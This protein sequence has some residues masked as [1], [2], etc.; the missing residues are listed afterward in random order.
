[1]PEFAYIARDPSGSRTT[2]VVSASSEREAI[3]AI[4]SRS[5]F[6]VEV[7]MDEPHT[8][9]VRRRRISGQ[10]MVNTYGQLSALL[11][12][13]VS[14]LRSLDVIRGQISHP[15]LSAVL[16]DIRDR[17]EDGASLAEAMGRHP[18]VFSEIAVS[19]V[20]AGGEG[21]FLEEALDR[22]AAFAEQQD[23]L[24]SRVIGA[25]A[26]PVFLLVLCT[27]VVTGLMIFFVPS[28]EEIFARLRERGELPLPTE[29]LL[30]TSS[31][32]KNWGWAAVLAVIAIGVL[33]YR[34]LQTVNGR[35][36]LDAAKLR[37]PMA[38]TIFQSLAVSRFCRVLGTLL[39]NGVPILRSL[40]ISRDAASNRVLSSAIA[41]ASE[42]I[43]AGQALA[44]PLGRCD[45]F[46][47]DVVE[48]IAVAE[49]SNTLDK[50]LVNIADRLD[51]NTTRRLELLVRLI[52]PLMLLGLAGLV[53]MIVIALLIPV[54]RM[55]SSI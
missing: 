34:W 31:T 53:L 40:E 17:V 20:R 13:G 28:F 1:M 7:K 23:D 44:E 14:L 22:V 48:I 52:E 27:I 43:S 51:R 39:R 47:R 4:S 38:G 6:P 35:H 11:Q 16:E 21:G 25:L 24:K 32:M 19:M 41:E 46:P 26:Y 15:G 8:G 10:L 54:L 37:M 12:S 3:A 2:G 9:V 42:N 18:K 55:S 33:F 49:E 30:W 5:L 50:V 29:I 36:S 45:F